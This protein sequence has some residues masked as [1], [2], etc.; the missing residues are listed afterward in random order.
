M[1]AVVERWIAVW[2]LP[3]VTL[4]QSIAYPF[5]GIFVGDD[6]RLHAIDQQKDQLADLLARF[7]NEFDRKI[8]SSVLAFGDDAPEGVKSVDALSGFRN[9]VCIAAIAHSH[10]LFAVRRQPWGIYFAEAFDFY[11]WHLSKLLNRRITADTPATSAIHQL[12][13]LKP[14]CAPALGMR[15]LSADALDLPLLD[16]IMLRW[17][18]LYTKGQDDIGDRRLFRSLDMARAACRM[19]G[20]ADAS[21][22]DQGRSAALWVS[23]FEILAHD[24]KSSSRKVLNLL[25]KVAWHHRELEEHERDARAGTTPVKTNLAGEI[26]L[27]LNR[28]RNDFLHGNEI[29][30]STILYGRSKRNVLNFAAPLYR[31]ALTAYLDLRQSVPMPNMNDDPAGAGHW[32]ADRME[33]EAPQKRCERALLAADEPPSKDEDEDDDNI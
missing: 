27:A 21:I 13:S 26:Y 33:F 2:P 30:V 6:P 14:Q 23:A 9:A 18:E 4:G 28:A 7:R 17:G 25:A 12:A 16:A 19:P 10:S 24:G 31:M 3:N 22:L 8:H 15:E 29:S 11:P 32:I 1:Q 20:S 5:V